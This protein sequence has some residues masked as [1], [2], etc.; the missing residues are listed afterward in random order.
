MVLPDAGAERR[1]NDHLTVGG[2]RPALAHLRHGRTARRNADDVGVA[3]I[4][5]SSRVAVIEDR[6]RP[7]DAGLA[8]PKLVHSATAISVDDVNGPVA[9]V[10]TIHSSARER[11]DVRDISLTKLALIPVMTTASANTSPAANTPIKKRRRRY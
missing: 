3:I 7:L 5:P 10:D 1:I 8:L 4:E 11:L 9:F 6:R 2:H